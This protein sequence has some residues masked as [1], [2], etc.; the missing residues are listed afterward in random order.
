MCIHLLLLDQVRYVEATNNTILEI[1]LNI[2]LKNIMSNNFILE[3]IYL[4]KLYKIKNP[5]KKENQ[6]IKMMRS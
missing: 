5:T 4:K 2:H 3:E 1:L 6:K